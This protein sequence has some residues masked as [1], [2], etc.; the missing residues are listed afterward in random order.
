MQRDPL[1]EFAQHGG[2][3]SFLDCP[4]S[5]DPHDQLVLQIRGAVAE[6]ERSLTAERTRRGRQ[7]KREA[8]LLRPWTRVPF[9][10]QFDP[11]HPRDPRG[12][13]V[14]PVAAVTV[15]AMFTTFL[16]LFYTRAARSASVLTFSRSMSRSAPCANYLG[17]DG[18]SAWYRTQ[19]IW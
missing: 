14:D 4:M 18:A 8:G 17:L 9:G 5:Q 13:R 6:Y 11:E 1:E 15:A 16:A 10:Y 7:R 12:L 2:T 19:G 3:V